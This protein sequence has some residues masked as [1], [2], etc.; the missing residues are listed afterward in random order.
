MK[1]VLSV[2][3]ALVMVLAMLPM[4]VFADPEP[5][6]PPTPPTLYEQARMLITSLVKVSVSQKAD[7]LSTMTQARH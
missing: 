4:A 6:D 1:K 7:M 3:I 5:G 2:L